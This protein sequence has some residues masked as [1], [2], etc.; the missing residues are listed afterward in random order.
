M[1]AA[2]AASV[3]VCG[4]DV[5]TPIVKLAV[6]VALVVVAIVVAVVGCGSCG[7]GGCCSCCDCRGCSCSCY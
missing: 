7:S 1:L 6:A 4:C 3:R 5:F 2:T